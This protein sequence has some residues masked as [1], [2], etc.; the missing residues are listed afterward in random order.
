[1]KSSTDAGMSQRAAGGGNAVRTAY[2]NGLRRASGKRAQEAERYLQRE[3]SMRAGDGSPLSKTGI[4]T[5]ALS[6]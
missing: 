6:G 2:G 1:M 3:A 5:Y 4:W